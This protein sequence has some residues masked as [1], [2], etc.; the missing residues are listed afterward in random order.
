MV[1]IFICPECRSEHAEPAEAHFLLAVVC[2]DCA[3]A[4][5]YDAARLEIGILEM[6]PAAA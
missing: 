1:H 3:L 4:R 2:A 5:D 6:I